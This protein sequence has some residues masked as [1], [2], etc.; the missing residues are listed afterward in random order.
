MSNASQLIAQQFRSGEVN[1]KTWKDVIYNIRDYGASELLSDNTNYIRD[2][3]SA[4]YNAGGGTVIV[5]PGEY[6][7]TAITLKTNV[8][9]VSFGGKLKLRDGVCVNSSTS[10]YII[11]N[12]DGL[13]G[14]FSNVA[15]V[16][17]IV[18]GNGANNATFLVADIITFG[19]EN[20]NII[21][22][23]LYDAPD[24][25]IMFSGAKNSLC[26]GNRIDLGRDLGIYVND[27]L[28]GSNLYENVISYNRITNFPNGGIGLKR[29]STKTTVAL[30]AI[31]DCG[32]GITLEQASTATDYS[33]NITIIGNRIRNVTA[34]A[35]ID[36]R[37][38]PYCTVIGNRIENFAL[39]GLNIQG[40]THHSSI[41]GNVITSDGSIPVFGTYRAGVMLTSRQNIFPSYNT[42]MGNTVEINNPSGDNVLALYMLSVESKISGGDHNII[43]G[44]TFKTNATY[45]GRITSAY[46]KNLIANNVFS[47]STNDIFVNASLQNTIADND[48]VNNTPAGLDASTE[49]YLQRIGTQ[50]VTRSNSAPTSGTWSVGDICENPTPTLVRNIDRWKCINA[51]GSGTWVAYGCGTGTTAQRPTL[52]A[53]DA[54]YL[55][56]DTTTGTKIFWTGTAWV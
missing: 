20:A 34:S 53:N 40:D 13:G 23:N 51:T 5:P 7:F 46:T 35:G 1:R 26:I 9:L 27:G 48:Y 38:A 36:I 39:V 50:K 21:N 42:I 24:S 30:N 52:T 49:T 4:A 25:G 14:L 31:N 32:N 43:A 54:G 2:A 33:K 6:L 41:I 44:N 12:M 56:Y 37:S 29:V 15:C 19:G 11:H 28:N 47:G 3:I 16:D 55:Y 10:Y 8:R 22:C 17:L 18:D 45:G